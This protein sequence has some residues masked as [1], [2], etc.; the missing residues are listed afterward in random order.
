MGTTRSLEAVLSRLSVVLASERSETTKHA[1]F[2]ISRMSATSSW[3]ASFKRSPQNIEISGIQNRAFRGWFA[4][5][6]A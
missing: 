6:V 2:S 3:H 4:P 1:I 5:G